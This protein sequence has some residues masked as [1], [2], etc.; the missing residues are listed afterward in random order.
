M[1]KRINITVI[2]NTVAYHYIVQVSA[3]LPEYE[4]MCGRD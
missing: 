3:S 1:N 4:A 2:G